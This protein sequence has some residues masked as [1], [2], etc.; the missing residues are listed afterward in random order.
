MEILLL[1]A[2][3]LFVLGAAGLVIK[4]VAGILRLA[5][6]LVLLPFHLLGAA[7]ALVAGL[8]ALPF[9]LVAAVG[10]GVAAIVG[11][12]LLPFLPLALLVLAGLGLASLLRRRGAPRQRTT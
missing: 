7:L 6:D 9:L 5:L 4:L 2:L 12:L 11:A 10:V 8:L 3:A 1:G